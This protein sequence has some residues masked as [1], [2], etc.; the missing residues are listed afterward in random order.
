MSDAWAPLCTRGCLV[1]D[2]LTFKRAFQEFI[3]LHPGC[4]FLLRLHPDGDD[5]PTDMSTRDYVS[6]ASFIK[7][8]AP[9]DVRVFVGEGE[10]AELVRQRL[11]AKLQ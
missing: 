2:V 11:G 5:E 7:E 10:D 1:L 8:M 6:V 3:L 9:R 4:A